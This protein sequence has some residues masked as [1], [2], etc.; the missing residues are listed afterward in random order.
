MK[1]VIEAKGNTI[2]EAIESAL[3]LLGCDR[4][5]V[6]VEVLE[7]PKSGFLGFGRQKAL[8]RCDAVLH[9]HHGHVSVRSLT[10]VDLD[11]GRA[12]VCG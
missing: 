1:K 7:Q 9:I 4:D 11:A 8:G 2:E 10:E 3:L 6:S 12:R 5:D